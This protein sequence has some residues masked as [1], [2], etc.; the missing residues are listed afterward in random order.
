MDID[1]EVFLNIIFPV[2]I[3]LSRIAD[4]TLGTI[5]ILLVMQGKRM[6]APILGFFE[7]LIWISVAG[8]VMGHLNNVRYYVAWALGFALGNYFGMLVEDKMSIGI[9]LLR[10]II[11]D[12]DPNFMN[13]LRAQKIGATVVEGQGKD[14]SVKIIF[15]VL[16]RRQLKQAETL[17]G[18]YCPQAI[19][20]VEN[21]RTAY[22]AFT[23]SSGQLRS[24]QKIF[25][26]IRKS[27]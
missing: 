17:I 16:E 1:S 20:T 8:Q 27:K 5:R 11:K 10:I 19:Y 23:A 25:S 6:I 3:C 9:V 22:N 4:V 18:T 15:S 7:V 24:L 13:K 26:E 2:I 14:S 12:P 21:I